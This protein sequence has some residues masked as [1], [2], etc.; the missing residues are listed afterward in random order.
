MNTD[1]VASSLLSSQTM[2]E[3]PE[4]ETP[5]RGISPHIKGQTIK[6]IVI[7]DARLRWPV[8]ASIKKLLPGQR[9]QNVKRRGKYLLLN[10]EVGTLIIHL[11]MSGSLRIVTAAAPVQKHDHVDIVFANHKI[12]RLRDPRR[13]G[14]VLFTRRDPLQ[15]K[16]LAGLGP[17]PLSDA[18]N[19]EYLYAKSRQR[20]VAVKSLLMDSKIVVG[21]GNIYAN[22]ALFL[23]GIHPKKSAG[24]LTRPQCARLTKAVKK[25]LT[26]A[27]KA[28]GTTLR[29]FTRSDG[30]PGYFRLSLKLYGKQGEPCPRCHKPISHAVIGQRASY[31]CTH[32]Q[33]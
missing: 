23:A 29:D 31:Y 28:G 1:F 11:G 8:P 2:P 26:M 21:V 5:R 9:I 6:T 27:I 4:V 13:F 25:T 30:Q 22:E 24:K 19:A 33:T 10:T 18:F 20:K 16:L 12:L 32:C 15:H 17:E 14:A 7:R 3:L